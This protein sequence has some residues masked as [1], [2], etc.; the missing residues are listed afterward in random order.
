MPNFVLPP[1]VIDDHGD[2][3]LYPDVDTARREME[4]IDVINGVYDAFDSTGARLSLAARESVVEISLDPDTDR[5]PGE[6]LRRLRHFIDRV[7]RER[8]GVVDVE[9]APLEHLID[10][11]A[12]FFDVQ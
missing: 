8:V 4:A 6:L 3:A 5:E 9:A 7:G 12:R 1:I 11:L 10:A 2:I